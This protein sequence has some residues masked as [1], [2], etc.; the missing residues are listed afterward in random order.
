MNK[1]IVAGIGPGNTEYMV[2]AALTAI[3]NARVLVGGSRALEQFAGE[4]QLTMAIKS[5]IK[6]V[7]EFIRQ[8]LMEQEVVVMVSGDPGYYS[9]LDS[10]RREFSEDQIRVIPGIS[11][12]QLAFSRLAL[13]WH[14]AELLSMHGREP[15]PEKLIYSKGRILGFLTDGRNNSRTVPEKLMAAGWPKD[16]RLYICSRLSY[17]DE[18]II[19]T[20]LGEA[21]GVREYTHCILVVK[22]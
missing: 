2:P 20:T 16:A 21:S 22:D 19:A 15:A 8:Q 5:D 10:L 4:D 6:A 1:I 11:S 7:M 18:E 9:L 13:P 3:R 17:D 12:M 14:D